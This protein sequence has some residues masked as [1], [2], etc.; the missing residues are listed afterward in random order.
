[1]R[2]EE[3]F[4]HS[5]HHAN[6]YPIPKMLTRI[7]KAIEEYP[8]AMLFELYD[9]GYRSPFEQLVACLLSIRT[10]DEVSPPVALHLLA[11]ATHPA[12]LLKIPEADLLEIVKP[13]TFP[14]QK[15]ASLRKISETILKDFNGKTPTDFSGLTSLPG[16]GP[17]CANL[18]LGI[19]C[20]KPSI[21]VDIHVHRV[22][23]R[24]GYVSAP[25]PQKTLAQLE[26]RLP[27]DRWVE[28]NELLVPFGKHIC[29]GRLPKCSTCPVLE[30]CEQN[31]VERHR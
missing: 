20:G 29:T 28:L 23:N 5:P 25:T 27:R 30:Y 17:K 31:G 22:T 19:A 16:I 26:E 18:V 1:M 7:R 15:A 10:L 11:R 21:G 2:L 8:K 3:S 13:C 12:Q 24:W 4:P 14:V 9:L 6:H